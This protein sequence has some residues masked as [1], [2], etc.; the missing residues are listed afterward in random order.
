MFCSRLDITG[1]TSTDVVKTSSL[2]QYWVFTCSGPS[3]KLRHCRSD[4]R[5]RTD[6]KQPGKANVRKNN[7][8][9]KIIK[10]LS[11]CNE[12]GG[13]LRQG[14]LSDSNCDTLVLFNEATHRNK[15]NPTPK[16]ETDRPY[17]SYSAF[18][19]HSQVH[20]RSQIS[21]T[22][23]FYPQV[24]NQPPTHP[25]S[26]FLSCTHAKTDTHTLVLQSLTVQ[27]KEDV[28]KRWEKSTVPTAPWQ[29]TP[30][31]GPWWPS[32]ISQIPALL[33]SEAKDETFLTTPLSSAVI[34]W[35][36]NT[37]LTLMGK[38]FEYYVF[39]ASFTF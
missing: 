34:W 7:Q 23:I 11:N 16:E 29:L 1:I 37:I 10:A 26:P 32:N 31:T 19:S 20:S 17:L 2:L 35:S 18:P 14:N 6:W 4:W 9:I 13:D 25:S 28:M 8:S 12:W 36:N 21:L 30:V 39:F 22:H 15:N 3:A 27:S 33:R 24:H 5:P 38:S